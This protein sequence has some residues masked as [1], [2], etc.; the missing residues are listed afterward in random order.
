MCGCVFM[1][2]C[3]GASEEFCILLAGLIQSC[4][5]PNSVQTPFIAPEWFPTRGTLSYFI[6][7]NNQEKSVILLP[8]DAISVL[9]I[10][11]K[12]ARVH[13]LDAHE[14]GCT[15]TLLLLL[16]YSEG[17][18]RAYTVAAV[19][20]ATQKSNTTYVGCPATATYSWVAETLSFSSAYDFPCNCWKLG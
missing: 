4:R 7:G 18:A 11:M 20:V 10:R 2:L 17:D 1:W 9:D 6:L 8:A 16:P 14:S 19:H 12:V 5:V 13:A 15:V 3:V